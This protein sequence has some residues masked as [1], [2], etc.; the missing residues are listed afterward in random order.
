MTA[1]TIDLRPTARR[2]RSSTSPRWLIPALLMLTLPPLI[3][4]V[5][6]LV[7]VVIGAALT[8]DTARF[9]ASPLPIFLHVLGA[10]VYGLVGILQFVTKFRQRH[11]AWHRRA[12][13]V[14]LA[15]ALLV[16]LSALWMTLFYP[17]SHDSG[18]LLFLFRLLF[19]VWMLVAIVAGFVAIRRGD[20]PGHRAWMVRAYAIG[21]GAGTQMLTLMV[22]GMVLGPPDVLTHDLLM[23]AAWAINLA[24]AEAVIRRG[25]RARRVGPKM[26]T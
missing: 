24:V 20:V 17:R 22:G 21:M 2:P 16:G 9:L 18:D 1:T 8:P 12:G 11:F 6:H 15:F 26:R 19:A 25:R 14:L 7:Q 4:G 10:A 23:G 3:V 13:R 5:V